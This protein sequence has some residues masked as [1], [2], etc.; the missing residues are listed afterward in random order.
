MPDI[1]FAFC[2]QD[3]F[4]AAQAGPQSNAACFP[5]LFRQAVSRC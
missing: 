3:R 5:L 1:F 2:C 4:P